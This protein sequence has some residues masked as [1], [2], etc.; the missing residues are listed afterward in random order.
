[1]IWYS[2]AGNTAYRFQFSRVPSGREAVGAAH[3]SEFACV[4]GTL[5]IAGRAANAP[6]YDSVDETV[7]DQMQGCWTNFAKNGNPNGGSVPR[8]PKFDATAYMDV[9]ANGPVAREGLRREFCQ[10]FIENISRSNQAERP[11]RQPAASSHDYFE[12]PVSG[13]EPSGLC[14]STARRATAAIA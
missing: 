5:A 12:P 9:T 13:S 14:W 4:F 10:L 7:S 8:W 2:R 3:G 11:R 6:K 1:M